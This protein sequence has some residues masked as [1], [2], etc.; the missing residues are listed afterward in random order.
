M[1]KNVLWI[2]IG[3][4]IVLVVGYT[5]LGFGKIRC[6]ERACSIDSD[7]SM[8]CTAVVPIPCPQ[9][10]TCSLNH[11]C[12]KSSTIFKQPGGD[13]RD[14]PCDA[15]AISNGAVNPCPS[16]PRG[17]SGCSSEN[18]EACLVACNP[19]T[20][21][22]CSQKKNVCMSYHECVTNREPSND[23]PGSVCFSGI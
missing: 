21:S 11:Q 14:R 9:G 15:T 12:V 17:F 16:C 1:N 7:G 4:I 22:Y 8:I 13:I 10:M 3:A 20:Q 19:E 2:I 5:F 6:Q 18:L 23:G